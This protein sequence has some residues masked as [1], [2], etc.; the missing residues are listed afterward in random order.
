MCYHFT[1]VEC[2]E[3][4]LSNILIFDSGVGGL[5]VFQKI[6]NQLPTENYVYL[7]DNEAYPYGELKPERLTER[8]TL[9]VGA[10]VKKANIDMVVIACNSASTVV[11]PAL[12]QQLSIPVVGVVPAIKPAALL[13]QKSI[14]L[15]ATPATVARQYTHD[16][17]LK[18]APSTPVKLLGSTRL[19]TM[20]E[21]KLRGR[22]VALEELK[23]L[24]NPLIGQIDV[25]VLGCTH[26]PLLR[27]EI[28]EVLGKDVVL[29]DSGIA[30][31]KRV[32]ELLK[33]NS[34][35]KLDSELDKKPFSIYSSAAPWEGAA[36]N[37][38][39][40][41]FGFSL[42]QTLHLQDV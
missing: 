24:L 37:K 27:D 21:E 14:G 18:F 13:S 25:A 36:L 38:G 30:I 29:V 8:V 33:G 9:L 42:I 17:I 12:R 26:F 3:K 28:Q 16:L 41:Q 2:G 20:A 5:S 31:A 1:L 4:N 11:L 35:K 23:Q 39:L 34:D 40:H 22:P 19:V 32:A 10:M 15:I 6:Q 7:F